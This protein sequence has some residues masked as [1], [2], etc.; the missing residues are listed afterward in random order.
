MS[1][2]DVDALLAEMTLD[3]K[4]SLTAGADVWRTVEV[5]RLGIRQVKMTD[6]PNGA[7]G[8]TVN[9]VGV[10]SSLCIPSGS[11]LGATWDREAVAEA[12]AAVA[13][14]A[15]EKSARILLAPTVNLHR[16]PLWGRNFE[17]FSEDPYL[18]GQLGTAYIKAVQ[19]E[20]VVATVKHLVCN[21]T[22][23]ERRMCSSEVDERA[24]RELYLLPFEMAIREGNVKA[25]MTSYNRLNG[26][27]LA[28]DARILAGILRGE[29]GFDGIVMTDWWALLS[30]VE[31][32][33]AGLDIEMPGP[34]RSFGPA[35]ASAVREG[36]VKESFLD[37]KVRRMIG[38]FDQFGA[39][40]DEGEEIEQPSDTA[41]DRDMCRRVA[42][43]AMVLL[44]NEAS[45]L[46]LDIAGLS[47]VALIGPCAEELSIMGG[48]S[49]R[50]RAHYSLSLA[51]ILSGRLGGDVEVVTA[52]GC[53]MPSGPGQ[54]GA[55]A[56]DDAGLLAEAARA[57]GEADVAIVVVGTTP[58][59]ES[60]GYDRTSMDL[61]GE[62][63]ELVRRV[64]AA[65]P[66]TVVVLNTG[67]PVT[68]PFAS[69]APAL[70]QCW[71]GGEELARA[72]VDVLVGDAGPGGRLPFSIPER[73][74]HCPA[75]GNFPA[76]S[77][78][79]LYG[80]GL[81]VGYRWYQARHLGVAYPFGHGLSY[82]TMKTGPAR[83]STDRLE[84]GGTVIVKVDVENTGP[85]EG[86][87]VV[88]VYVAPPGGGQRLPAGRLRPVRAL[89]GFAKVRLG[90]GETA[91]AEV[92]LNERSFAYYD[93]ADTAWP[94]LA[95]RLHGIDE[96]SGRGLHRAEAGWYLDSGIYTVEV[97]R[98]CEDIVARLRIEVVGSVKPLPPSAPVG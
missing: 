5:G 98:S 39:L 78:K 94:A 77:S 91:T 49:A 17:A 38:L 36:A 82:T 3:E 16:H 55:G 8:S 52:K 45:T 59:W 46:P 65:N 4:A 73:V 95:G 28:D 22:E 42:A 51:E 60:E 56:S 74:E 79:V 26:R 47:K 41:S 21:E 7:R 32:A 2:R 37:D 53:A 25:V 12:S 86:S 23:H 61:P 96:D 20:G 75:F 6:G 80:E 27:Y 15:R 89:K 93:V 40:D 34:G 9:G 18:T 68:M 44:K 63:A 69:L 83:L 1:G 85:R 33:E 29:W 64:I 19:A 71:F 13:R 92:A 57:A 48:G 31:A 11:A 14:Q 30:T 81:L 43:D 62:Q 97:G 84:E 50:V 88:Q 70:L 24:L 90:P 10:T 58:K 87:E 67:A 35:L 72:L 76:E 66:R 54:E